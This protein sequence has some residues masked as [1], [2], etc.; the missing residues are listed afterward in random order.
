MK[1]AFQYLGALVVV[2]VGILS[3]SYLQHRFDQSD[4]RHA[5]NAVR[6]TKPEGPQAS[7]LEEKV[8]QHFQ[9]APD[10]LFWEPR[11]ESKVQG[12]VLVKAVPPQGGSNLVWEVDLVRMSVIPVTPEAKS[13]FHSQP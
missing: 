13:L 11:L 1:S 7:T 9:V 5:V 4:L 10:R 3:V 2:V 6:L 12:T 8:A